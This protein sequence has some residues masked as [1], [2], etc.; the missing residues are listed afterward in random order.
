MTEEEININVTTKMMNYLMERWT[1]NNILESARVAAKESYYANTPRFLWIKNLWL[2]DLPYKHPVQSSLSSYDFSKKLGDYSGDEAQFSE[3]TYY[4]SDQKSQP[5]GYFILVLLS[6]GTILLQQLLMNKSQKEQMELQTVDGQAAV[7]S[8]MMMW[9]MP[10]MFGFFA[11]MYSA[12][13]SLYMIVSTVVSTLSTIII[14]YF[15]EK[16][17]KKKYGAD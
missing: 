3:L 16:S 7:Q 8:K 15:V 1:E 4:L 10:I 14:N 13:F 5:N 11:F 12:S 2:P 9:M 17:F 6:I